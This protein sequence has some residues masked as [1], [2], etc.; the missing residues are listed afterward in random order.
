MNLNIKSKK[1]QCTFY[2]TSDGKTFDNYYDA[3]YYEKMKLFKKY[4]KEYDERVMPIV[5]G[6]IFKIKNFMRYELLKFYYDEVQSYIWN[7]DI[8]FRKIKYPCYIIFGNNGNI[9]L[10]NNTLGEEL[11]KW[12]DTNKEKL[13]KV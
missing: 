7:T 8:D 13:K 3:E 1:R 4:E 12:Y 9:Y 2:E 6:N 11:Y 10:I 5:E